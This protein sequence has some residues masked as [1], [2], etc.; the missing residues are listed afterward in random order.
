[1]VTTD[2]EKN[3]KMGYFEYVDYLNDLHGIAEYD[4]FAN[5]KC[6]SKNKKVSRSDEGLV[7]HHVF[8][9]YAPQL[10]HPEYAKQ[11]PY[12]YQ[13]AENLVYCDL[14]EHLLLHVKITLENYFNKTSVFSVGIGGI[15][16]Y[17]APQLNDIYTGK[18]FTQPYHVRQADLV[19]ENYSEYIRILQ[20][21]AFTLFPGFPDYYSPEGQALAE[22]LT[23]LSKGSDGVPLER[24]AK[25]FFDL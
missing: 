11:F 7:C 17:I 18:E 24:I 2:F 20:T 15:V 4:Y 6:A 21:L 1:M 12:K 5:E 9:Y 22:L 10:S 25:S 16:N 13:K 8:E 3:L 23:V 19:R 14:L